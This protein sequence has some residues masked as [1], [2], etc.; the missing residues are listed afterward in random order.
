MTRIGLN[1]KGIRNGFVKTLPVTMMSSVLAVFVGGLGYMVYDTEKSK[2]ERRTTEELQ[3]VTA[4]QKTTNETYELMTQDIVKL[5]EEGITHD[6]HFASGHIYVVKNISRHEKESFIIPFS[7]VAQ[8]G[9]IDEV[10]EKGCDIA[11]KPITLEENSIEIDDD[12][13]QQLQSR[14]NNFFERHCSGAPEI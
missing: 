1:T 8:P 10:R 14:A 4:T 7:E 3:K 6:F 13:M 11:A 5:T 9:W 2:A 12:V